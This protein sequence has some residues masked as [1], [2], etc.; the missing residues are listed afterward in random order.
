MLRR[1]RHLLALAALLLVA[2]VVPGA[3]AVPRPRPVAA[4][5]V[6][7][8][9][10]ERHR[11]SRARSYTNQTVRVVVNPTR[12]GRRLRLRLSNRFGTGPLTIDRVTVARRAVGRRGRRQLAC[13]GDLRRGPC[14]DD[15]RAAR[16]SSPSPVRLRYRAF[17]DLAV[18]IY[19]RGPAG[20][21]TQHPVANE[22]G[23]YTAVGD[24]TQDSFRRELRFSVAVMAASHA[25][26][27]FRRHGASARWSPS[28]T[29]SRT[30]SR[31]RW[32]SD[33]ANATPAG[34]TS[35]PAASPAATAPSRSSTRASA[36]TGSASTELTL[37]LWAQRA[38]RAWTA[39]CSPSPALSR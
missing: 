32:P 23:S 38:W 27:T 19:V 15:S 12:G 24:R 7:S 14:R 17:A 26:W 37:P 28:A 34:P 33:P 1:L 2:L 29:R 20:P 9:R 22:I 3:E 6:G 25:G 10:G 4:A 13:A 35:S 11:R 30:G 31:A 36:A 21:A 39:T 16:M 5:P 8:E 18:S